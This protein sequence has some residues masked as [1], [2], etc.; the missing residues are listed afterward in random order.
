MNEQNKVINTLRADCE[1]LS[2]DIHMLQGL[3]KPLAIELKRK[4]PRKLRASLLAYAKLLNKVVEDAENC[5]FCS[6]SEG[7]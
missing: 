1:M 7:E 2:A 5:Y 6:E 3:Y 4:V